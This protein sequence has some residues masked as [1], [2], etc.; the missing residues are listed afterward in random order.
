MVEQAE[1]NFFQREKVECQLPELY[2]KIGEGQW[3]YIVTQRITVTYFASC[4]WFFGELFYHQII[5]YWLSLIR[6]SSLLIYN[7]R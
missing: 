4:R 1:Y 7:Q 2:H 3:L 6:S 5:T